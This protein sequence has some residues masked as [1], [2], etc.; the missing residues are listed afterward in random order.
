MGRANACGHRAAPPATV[1]R[2]GVC[3][4]PSY[5]DAARAAEI[6]RGAGRVPVVSLPA[7][8]RRREVT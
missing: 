3:A 8:P 4:V 5:S 7:T 2:R 6:R 1:P